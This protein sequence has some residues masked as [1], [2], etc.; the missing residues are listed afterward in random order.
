MIGIYLLTIITEI[1]RLII[2]FH[3]LLGFPYR[4]GICK[5]ALM[6]L[7]PVAFCLLYCIPSLNIIYLSA[8]I[9]V[10]NLI[11]TLFLFNESIKILLKAFICIS[12]VTVTWDNLIIQVINL[13]YKIEETT[14]IGAL[15]QQCLCNGIIIIL[16]ATTW[17]I[18]KRHGLLHMLNYSQLSN[19]VFFLFFSSAGLIA[20]IN[21]LSYII[22]ENR[23]PE[24]TSITYVAIIVL[25]ILF[26]IICITLIFL[27][28]SREQYK[29]RNRLREEYSEKQVDYYK[30]LLNQE[31]DTKKF[32]HDIKNHIICI[33]ELLDSGK[34]EDVKLYL[35]DIHQSLESSRR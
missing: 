11:T 23:I 2:I 4:K 35:Q 34:L 19:N 24:K 16:L 27:F 7:S 6:L 15:F 29:D 28:Y 17:L 31:E 26:Q 18:I 33:E 13:F 25:S 22:Y 10:I 3:G 9:I 20:Y 5:Y 14:A 21:S 8:F 1:T 32:R 12:V 30:T